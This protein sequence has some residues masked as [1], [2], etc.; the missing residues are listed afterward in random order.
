MSC[1][2]KWIKKKNLTHQEMFH[3]F[4]CLPQHF[5][6]QF[7]LSLLFRWLDTIWWLTVQKVYNAKRRVGPSWLVRSSSLLVLQHSNFL[8]K[9]WCTDHSGCANTPSC[10]STLAIEASPWTSLEALEKLQTNWHKGRQNSVGSL[11]SASCTFTHNIHKEV[12]NSQEFKCSK[13]VEI[14]N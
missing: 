2:T 7:S 11:R 1:N 5:S 14:S 3:V 8:R 4:S 10:R 6:V 13:Y 12:D 9:S